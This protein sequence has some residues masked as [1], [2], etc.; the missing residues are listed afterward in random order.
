MLGSH[1]WFVFIHEQSAQASP[2]II[3][4]NVDPQSH[5]FLFYADTKP[6]SKCPHKAQCGAHAHSAQ[7]VLDDDNANLLAAQKAL[8][9]DH[10]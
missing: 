7:F 9:L 4:S 6:L 10:Q 3:H 1:A 8:L 2:L 5:L